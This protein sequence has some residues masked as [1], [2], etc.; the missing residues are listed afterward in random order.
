MI[1]HISIIRYEIFSVTYNNIFDL[2]GD[3]TCDIIRVIDEDE[4]KVNP[5]DI[6]KRTFTLDETNIRDTIK[7]CRKHLGNRGDGWDYCKQS[8]NVYK[9]EI[10]SSRLLTMYMLYNDWNTE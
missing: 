7:W 3:Y 9:I 10:C 2:S 5:R 8:R 6:L 1:A 4:I